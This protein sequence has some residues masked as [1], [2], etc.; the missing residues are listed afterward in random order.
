[1]IGTPNLPRLWPRSKRGK[2]IKRRI[3][4][5]LI[6]ATR[7]KPKIKKPLKSPKRA[8]LNKRRPPKLKLKKRRLKTKRAILMVITRALMMTKMR[9]RMKV[10]KVERNSNKPL[11]ETISSTRRF[12]RKGVIR[13]EEPNGRRIRREQET[14]RT[15]ETLKS[16]RR[17]KRRISMMIL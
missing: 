13:S 4:R 14:K 1:V 7:P 16:K 3:L 5:A 9:M 2:K 15:T 8:A 12:P 17:K 10:E 11:V 6:V